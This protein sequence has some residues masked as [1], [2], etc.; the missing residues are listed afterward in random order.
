MAATAA[1]AAVAAAAKK[2]A[3]E[4]KEGQL[5]FNRHE[6]E[7]RKAR[8][9]RQKERDE[10]MAT[11]L[12]YFG[13]VDS[14]VTK[15][16]KVGKRTSS[17]E[18]DD[19]IVNQVFDISNDVVDDIVNDDGVDKEEVEIL[20]AMSTRRNA[21]LGTVPDP[22]N[23][24]ERSRLTI[25]DASGAKL[26]VFDWP[27]TKIM[28]K[29]LQ[30]FNLGCCCQAQCK[31]GDHH[32]EG[33]TT[34]LGVSR[35]TARTAGTDDDDDQCLMPPNPFHASIFELFHLLPEAFVTESSETNNLCAMTRFNNGM[36]ASELDRM[37]E[38]AGRNDEDAKQFASLMM[39]LRR[40]YFIELANIRATHERSRTEVD[41]RHEADLICARK[42]EDDD[43][44]EETKRARERERELVRNIFNSSVETLHGFMHN[45]AVRTLVQCTAHTSFTLPM[46]MI[47]KACVDVIKLDGGVERD[48]GFYFQLFANI[49]N[50]HLDT[51]EREKN[52]VGTDNALALDVYHADAKVLGVPPEKPFVPATNTSTGASGANQVAS[53]KRK[54]PND[55]V[56]NNEDDIAA[57]GGLGYGDYDDDDAD[58]DDKLP[59]PS[60]PPPPAVKE[61]PVAMRIVHPCVSQFKLVNA[62]HACTAIA[63][64]FALR[65][66][67][68]HRLGVVEFI[69]VEETILTQLN[70]VQMLNVG[71]EIWRMWWADKQEK[72]FAEMARQAALPAG[73]PR[74]P[75]INR[76]DFMMASEVVTA[77]ASVRAKMAEHGIVTY[78][79]FG[80]WVADIAALGAQ[81]DS[82]SLERALA[83][84]EKLEIFA[85]VI[86]VHSSSMCVARNGGHWFLFDSHGL[87]LPGYSSL[88][89]FPNR[90]QIVNFVRYYFNKIE[91][92]SEDANEFQVMQANTYSLFVMHFK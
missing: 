3:E 14:F 36:P 28:M 24:T 20:T 30:P 25:T 49:V 38:D 72:I 15:K 92:D 52:R 90:D 27:E 83:D 89:E 22:R 40:Q 54:N 84:A 10:K 73:A 68:A 8:I 85:A 19:V 39:R 46:P 55:A 66:V 61:K 81:E 62:H 2:E 77:N 18:D 4:P 5:S 44:A 67:T 57:N 45:L 69:G 56:D 1:A 43:Y 87:E 11:K 79:A 12:R 59:P 63:F 29:L 23:P 64:F 35:R 7:K 16:P 76:S 75:P 65:L 42:N 33:D 47:I 70:Y 51:L 34:V 60:P 78:E 82:P 26:Q 53:K 80:F 91:M 71:A 13:R 41:A 21:I 31:S 86:T 9:K 50:G 88:I 6:V 17:D 48:D 74:P 32:H 37:A 58:I